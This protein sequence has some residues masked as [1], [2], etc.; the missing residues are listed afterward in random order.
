MARVASAVAIAAPAAEVWE[1]YF[2]P[3][4]WPL[5]VDQF[6]AVVAADTYP[7]EGGTLRW[8]SGSAGRGEVSERVVEH[9]P[10]RL[11]RIAFADPHATGELET[12]FE[13]IEAGTRVRQE[14]SYELRRRGPF[15]RISD[16]L[17]VR[18]QMRASLARSLALLRAEV[19]G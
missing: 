2:D 19:E 4:T 3:V 14:L 8:R 5:W 11:H 1:A 15:V 12:S 13:I 17:F 10:R 16:V 9:R 7:E 18:A 6:A